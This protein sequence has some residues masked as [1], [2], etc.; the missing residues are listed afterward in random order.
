[1][2]SLAPFFMGTPLPVPFGTPRPIPSYA[3]L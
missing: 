2:L 1:M 3:L